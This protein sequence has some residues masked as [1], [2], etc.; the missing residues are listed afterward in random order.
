MFKKILLA[1]FLSAYVAIAGG[2]GISV[3]DSGTWRS[4]Q[5]VYV[6]DTGT[7]RSIQQVYVND[8]GTWRV[9]FASNLSAT[10]TAGITSTYV[11]GMGFGH[12]DYGFDDGTSGHGAYGSLSNTTFIGTV[13]TIN[14]NQ[15]DFG[16]GLGYFSTTFS[17]RGL[18]SDPG[19][20]AFT[21]LT[22]NPG[23]TLTTAS[24]TYL[25]SA[26]IA[27]WSWSS[28]PYFANGSSYTITTN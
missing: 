25:Y 14:D 28:G 2:A 12:Q 1:L 23:G 4:A 21:S 9:V 11:D 3:N 17:I 5:G 6:N 7:W 15:L 8:A 27:T 18:S 22:I 10:L 26:G 24:A 13:C 20:S 16:G 19:Q